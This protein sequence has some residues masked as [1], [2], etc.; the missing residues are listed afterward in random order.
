MREQALQQAREAAALAERN[1]IARDLHDSIKQQIFGINASAAAARAYWQRENMEGVRAAVEDIERSAEG[2][3][4]EMQ[5][6]LQQLR[7]APLE[8]TSLLEALHTQAQAL[9][10]RTG[11]RVE[12]DLAALPEQ[13]RF[14]PGTQ[15]AIFR[16]VQEAFANIARHARA[17]TIWLTLGSAWQALHITV[18]DDG[19]GFD[20]TQVRS[21]MGL[22]NLRERTRTLQGHLEVRSKIGAGTTVLITIPLVEALRNPQ[23]EVRERYELARALELARRGYQFCAKTSFLGVVLGLVGILNTLNPLFGLSVVASLPGAISG[24]ARGVY[25]RARV[26]ASAGRDN[27]AVLELVPLHYRTGLGLL[28]PAILDLLYLIKLVSSVRVTAGR[29]LSLAIPL[30]LVG[31]ILVSC[32]WYVRSTACPLHRLSL[33]EMGKELAKRKQAFARSS[34]ILGI[35]SISGVLTNHALFVFPP[36]TPAQQSATVMTLTLLVGGGMV[37]VQNGRYRFP[38]LDPSENRFNQQPPGEHPLLVPICAGDEDSLTSV[39]AAGRNGT[40]QSG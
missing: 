35:V 19:Q 8:N 30:C 12:V 25:Y 1:R 29:W 22:S 10:F 31:L 36:V 28:L 23:E 38:F 18:R 9:G 5:A 17:R 6:L 14:L 26:V 20:P 40:C 15:E 24:Y 32:W 27:R 39:L 33:P 2:A 13:D 7:P 37:L 3:Q 4:V 21:G 34:I 16:L 11:A